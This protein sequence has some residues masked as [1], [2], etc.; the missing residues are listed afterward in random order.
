VAFELAMADEEALVI[1]GQS[2]PPKTRPKKD[3]EHDNESDERHDQ[4]AQLPSRKSPAGRKEGVGV[5]LWI[6]NDDGVL[7][8]QSSSKRRWTVTER[9]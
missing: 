6:S 9:P 4:L 3:Q 8:D 7:R 5:G 2:P 1:E